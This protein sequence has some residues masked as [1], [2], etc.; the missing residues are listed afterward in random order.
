MKIFENERG[1]LVAIQCPYGDLV[2]Y[3]SFPRLVAWTRHRAL[4]VV[5]S[6]LADALGVPEEDAP[7]LLAQLLRLA[8]L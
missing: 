8:G 1:H 2:V 6:P 7:K 4:S 3:N 5:R